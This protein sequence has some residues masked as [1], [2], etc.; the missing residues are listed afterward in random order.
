MGGGSRRGGG[1]A[2]HTRDDKPSPAFFVNGRAVCASKYR[3]KRDCNVNERGRRVVV[4][5]WSVAESSL[6]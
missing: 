2:P 4:V 5:V 3:T 6:V 1:G